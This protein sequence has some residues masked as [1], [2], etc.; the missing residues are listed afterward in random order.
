[1]NESD[2]VLILI[3]EA[4]RTQSSDLGN[5]L[6]KRSLMQA[7]LR[8][9]VPLITER[10]KEKTI[11]RFGGRFDEYKLKDAEADGATVRYSMKVKLP[12]LQ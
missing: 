6:S 5:N 12:I 1:M 4:H 7:E 8:S 2:R 11:E 9:Q 10:H 3:D